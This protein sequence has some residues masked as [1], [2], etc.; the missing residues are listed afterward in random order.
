[1]NTRFKSTINVFSL[2]MLIALFLPDIPISAQGQMVRGVEKVEY[3]LK[4]TTADFYVSASENDNWSGKLAEPNALKTDGPF[5]TIGR[6]KLAVRNLK[7]EIYQPIKT[8][9][10]QTVSFMPER[11]MSDLNL[12]HDMHMAATNENVG[13]FFQNKSSGWKVTGNI[14]YNLKQGELKYCDAYPVDNVYQDN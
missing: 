8:A 4:G 5:A 14:F 2:L 12:A 13:F 11:E 1:M 10:E 6:A 9:V 3:E 7:Q